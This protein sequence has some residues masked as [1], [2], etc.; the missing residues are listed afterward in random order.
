MYLRHVFDLSRSR[1]VI[2]QVIILSAVC[3]FMWYVDTSCPG[4]NHLRQ[5]FCQSVK[6]FQLYR[7]SNFGILH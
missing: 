2:G 1:D 6:R 3:G 7:G 5:I 4:R